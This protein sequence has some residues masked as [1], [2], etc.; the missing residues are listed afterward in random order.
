MVVQSRIGIWLAGAGAAVL[1]AASGS[2]QAGKD[3][4]TRDEDISGTQVK[5]D[6]H[7]RSDGL[8]VYEYS[9]TAAESNKGIVDALSIDLRCDVQFKDTPLPYTAS[10]TEGYSGIHNTKPITP[11]AVQSDW[12]AS[13]GWG[14]GVHNTAYWVFATKPGG[15]ESNNRLISPA[16]PGL[17]VYTLAPEWNVI[18]WDYPRIPDPTLPREQDFYVDGIIAAPGCPG[19]VPP[20]ETPSFP[21]TPHPTERDENL[22]GLLSYT[23]P[24]KDRVRVAEGTGEVELTIRYRNDLDPKSFKVQPGWARHFF[25]PKAGTEE[26]VRLPL[27]VHKTRNRFFLEAHPTKVTPPRAGS[28]EKGP[29]AHALKDRDEFEFRVES[30]T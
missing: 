20:V 11:T 19:E 13:A 21:G 12:G 3:P 17:R 30:G 10:G 1:L 23:K 18:G 8:W 6:Y 16:A 2:A 9:M 29:P 26:T 25:H 14:I 15:S 22:N 27:K 4:A 7:Q 28:E 5:V 24:L